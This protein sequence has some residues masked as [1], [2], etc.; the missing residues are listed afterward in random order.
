MC[1]RMLRPM[2]N[3][4]KTSFLTSSVNI[5][6]LKLQEILLDDY[7]YVQDLYYNK[8]RSVGL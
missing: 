6:K 1:L 2:A 7:V 5:L 8:I 4:D 3:K